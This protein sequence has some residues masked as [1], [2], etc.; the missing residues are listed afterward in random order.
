MEVKYLIA[1]KDTDGWLEFWEPSIPR[2][3]AKMEYLSATMMGA[4]IS[5]ARVEIQDEE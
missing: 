2:A 4:K 1:V 3:W 5:M